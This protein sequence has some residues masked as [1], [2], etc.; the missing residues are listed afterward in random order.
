MASHILDDTAVSRLDENKV[1]ITFGPQAASSNSQHDIIKTRKRQKLRLRSTEKDGLQVISHA[2]DGSST[3]VLSTRA[4]K[5]FRTSPAECLTNFLKAQGLDARRQLWQRMNSNGE[6]LGLALPTILVHYLYSMENPQEARLD[7]T[8][9]T[10][11]G[12][13]IAYLERSGYS[14]EDLHTWAWIFSAPTSKVVAERF[15]AAAEISKPPVFVLL[16]VLSREQ[17]S[18]ETTKKL[19]MHCWDNLFAS[20][21]AKQPSEGTQMNNYDRSEAPKVSLEINAF[22]ILTTRLLRR[23]RETLPSAMVS[24]AEMVIT[25][26]KESYIR[27]NAGGDAAKILAKQHWMS[28]FL[29]TFLQRLSLPAPEKPF[30]SMRHNWEAQRALLE[31]ADEHPQPLDI[32][33]ESYRAVAT[34]LLAIQ[35]APVEQIYA[36]LMQRTWPPWRR[37][38]D[39][40]DVLRP[41]EADLSRVV[42]TIERMGEAG[43]GQEQFEQTIKILGGRE[44]DGTPTI[45]TRSLMKRRNGAQGVLT[46]RSSSGNSQFDWSARIRATRDPIEAWAAFCSLPKETK[47]SLSMYLAMFEKLQADKRSARIG[48]SKALPG[49]G[50]ET[51]AIPDDNLSDDE[52]QRRQPP[53]LPDLYRDMQEQ[54]I[55]PSGRCLTFLVARASSFRRGAQYLRDSDLHQ[56]GVSMLLGLLA[57]DVRLKRISREVIAASVQLICRLADPLTLD[58]ADSAQQNIPDASL[59]SSSFVRHTRHH[60]TSAVES[61]PLLHALRILQAYSSPYRPAWYALFK[62]LARQDVVVNQKL[63]GSP[64]N[65]I[66]SWEVLE[67]ALR[68]A[69]KDGMILDPAGFQIICYGLTKALLASRELEKYEAALVQSAAKVKSLWSTL[70]AG[71]SKEEQE[72]YSLPSLLSYIQ[73]SHIHAYVRLLGLLRDIDSIHNVLEWLLEHEERL[74]QSA[75]DS[76]NGRALLRRVLVSMRIAAEDAAA[77]SVYANRLDDIK[78]GIEK[79][80]SWGGW[81]SDDEVDAYHKLGQEEEKVIS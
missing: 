39:G 13:V 63:F 5:L 8:A 80:E 74:T 4:K 28:R 51:F 26:M 23:I 31:F 52:R 44:P 69:E 25:Y 34:V 77:D 36:G 16:Q 38:Q 64:M 58:K 7:S 50:R 9:K 70:T 75:L 35:K 21:V 71:V 60:E 66:L 42:R 45:P 57:P 43:Y 33:R 54:G 29:N 15:L 6:L 62:A 76:R 55:K 48:H 22:E 2:R 41:L 24:V 14:V 79:L 47:P 30:I 53:S 37:D 65:D 49:D 61:N 46:T 72:K 20:A 81:P 68:D 3:N 32:N 27:V 12:E 18:P 73:G 11:D 1:S 56:N 67:A 19:M 40:M 59:D 78:S 10:V 17:K